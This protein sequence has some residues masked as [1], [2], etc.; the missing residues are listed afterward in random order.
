[1][2]QVEGEG[3]S[4]RIHTHTHTHTH[5]HVRHACIHMADTGNVAQR[6]SPDT[7]THSTHTHVRKP[8]VIG[9]VVFVP[10]VLDDYCA[11]GRAIKGV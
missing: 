2:G 5:N 3:Y 7:P 10:K 1:M 4:E 9:G 6:K 11:R 8:Y